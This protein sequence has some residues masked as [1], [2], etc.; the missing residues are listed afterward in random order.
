DRRLPLRSAHDNPAI[1]KVYASMFG[2][3]GSARARRLLHRGQRGYAEMMKT[4]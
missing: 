4:L 1:K 3:P 2:K